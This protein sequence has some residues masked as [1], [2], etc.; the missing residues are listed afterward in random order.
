MAP[1]NIG[2]PSQIARKTWS[3]IRA[4]HETIE[5][6]QEMAHREGIVDVD[7]IPSPQVEPVSPT[8]VKEEA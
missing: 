4:P 2:S 1:P 7:V 6:E 5:V 8:L 3:S